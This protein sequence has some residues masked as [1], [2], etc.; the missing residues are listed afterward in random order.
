VIALEAFV[1]CRLNSAKAYLSLVLPALE[2]CLRSTGGL[3]LR[4][5][6]LLGNHKDF[7]EAHES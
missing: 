3:L 1:A 2:D 5:I 4:R 6:E 7:E